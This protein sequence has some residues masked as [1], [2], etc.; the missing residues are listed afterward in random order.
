MSD[1]AMTS[2][3]S[4]KFWTFLTVM[5][6]GVAVAVTLIDLTIK[7]AILAESNSMKLAMEEWETNYGQKVSG[8]LDP[9]NYPDANNNGHLSG[10]VLDSR[11]AGME[12]GSADNGDKKPIPARPRNRNKPSAPDGN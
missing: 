1:N 10:N 5:L 4:I 2:N 9:R 8:R 12:A 7:A 11:D 3:D 6:L